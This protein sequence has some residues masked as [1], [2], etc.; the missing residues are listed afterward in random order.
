MQ[1][2]PQ[3]SIW[4]NVA[5][6]LLTA[7]AGGTLSFSGIVS[8]ETAVHISA[9][10]ALAVSALNI[11]L[12]GY[13]NSTPGPLA[14]ADPPVVKAATAVADLPPNASPALISKTKAAIDAAVEAHNP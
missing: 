6:L 9:Y 13:T 12:H 11:V 4:L 14:P 8:P 10:A 1:I 2:S 7:I 5:L 3:V